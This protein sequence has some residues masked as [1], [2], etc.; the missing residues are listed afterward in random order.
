MSKKSV[1]VLLVLTLLL[2]ACQK[3]STYSEAKKNNSIQTDK[4]LPHKEVE[5]TEILHNGSY[6][7]IKGKYDD[8]IIV[9][10]RYPLAKSYHP[11]EDPKAKEAFEQLK[12]AMTRQGFALSDHYSGFRSY[13][14]QEELYATYVNQDGQENADRYSARPGYSE[15]QTGLAFDIIDSQG[16]L[17]EEEQASAWLL[18]HAPDYGFIVRYLKVQEAST[19]YQAESWHIRYIGKEAADIA[20]SGKTLEAYF[21]LKGGN[22]PN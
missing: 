21:H 8:I 10:K 15:H 5:Q 4:Q 7:Y 12:Q 22:Y 18:A 13:E 11:G 19:G 16:H 6:Y 14:K 17:L 2:T 1:Y 9:N 20:K 3:K